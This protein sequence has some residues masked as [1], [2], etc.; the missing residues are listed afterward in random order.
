MSCYTLKFWRSYRDHRLC[1]VTSA[2]VYMYIHT[3]YF[4]SANQSKRIK[5]AHVRTVTKNSGAL[6]KRRAVPLTR[7]QV[8][9][10]LNTDS[11]IYVYDA[12][13]I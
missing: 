2:Y 7:S 13:G 11:D 9:N 4:I 6:A 3:Y 5:R 12:Y 10:L 1:D 8:L